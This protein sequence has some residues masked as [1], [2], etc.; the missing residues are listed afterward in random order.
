M[1]AVGLKARRLVVLLA[2]ALLMLAMTATPAMAQ[3]TITHITVSGNKILNNNQICAVCGS[4]IGDIA[5]NIAV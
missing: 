5:V 4:T 1:T 3:N 2:L